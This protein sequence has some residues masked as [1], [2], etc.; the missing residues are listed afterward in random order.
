M[1]DQYSWTKIRRL[2]AQSRI[3]STTATSILTGASNTLYTIQI[4]VLCNT[5][6][7]DVTFRLFHHNTGTTYDQTTALFYDDTVPANKTI[8]LM[9]GTDFVGLYLDNSTANF[10]FRE[11]TANAI[12]CT[13]YGIEAK[14]G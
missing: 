5:T 12:T 13:V 7:S 11:G 10:A 1:N 9:E 8:I 14:Q 6:G 3:N 4:I 2:L